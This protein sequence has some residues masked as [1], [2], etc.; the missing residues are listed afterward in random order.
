MA[1]AHVVALKSLLEKKNNSNYEVFNLGTGK[2]SSV[3]EVIQSFEKVSG[4]KLNY[5]VEDRREGDVIAAYAETSKANDVLGWKT[6][7]SLDDAMD[8]AWKWEQKIRG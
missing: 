6:E 5:K 1:K 4:K 8:S 3:L 7:L 2:G